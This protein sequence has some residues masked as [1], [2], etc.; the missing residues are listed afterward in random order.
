MLES[1]GHG[2]GLGHNIIHM[3]RKVGSTSSK[4]SEVDFPQGGVLSPQGVAKGTGDHVEIYLSP[5]SPHTHTHSPYS[6]RE[7]I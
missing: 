3:R 7:T 6:F 4:P 5:E 2:K 1:A